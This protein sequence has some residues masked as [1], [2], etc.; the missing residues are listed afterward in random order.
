MGREDSETMIGK[1]LLHD[2]IKTITASKIQQSFLSWGGGGECPLFGIKRATE[3]HGLKLSPWQFPLE[4]TDTQK[5]SK[6]KKK[7]KS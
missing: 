6:E 3:A 2:K 4:N 7:T 5:S 1:G